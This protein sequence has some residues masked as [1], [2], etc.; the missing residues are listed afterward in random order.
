[1][2]GREAGLVQ[3]QDPSNYSASCLPP[4]IA[5][6]RRVSM[7]S[8]AILSGS[9]TPGS[10]AAQ[11]LVRMMT[12]FVLGRRKLASQRDFRLQRPHQEE[13]FPEGI[14]LYFSTSL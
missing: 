9:S 5:A 1:M 4:L 2:T 6:G 10:A 11:T 3:V 13:I 7:A 12:N 14:I 8:P